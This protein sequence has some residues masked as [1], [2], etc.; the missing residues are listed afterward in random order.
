MAATLDAV[1]EPTTAQPPTGALDPAI[2][3]MKTPKKATPQ[4][5]STTSEEELERK[6]AFKE[7]NTSGDM[8]TEEALKQ[9]GELEQQRLDAF[10]K[11]IPPQP[12]KQNEMSAWGALAIAIGAFASL[13]T[14]QPLTTAM[15]AAASAMTAMQ[16]QNQENFENAFQ[17]WD[18]NVKLSLDMQ[19]LESSAYQDRMREWMSIRGQ[20]IQEERLGV[21]E[22]IAAGNL[23]VK[24]DTLNETH[25]WHQMVNDTKLTALTLKDAT[26]MKELDRGMAEGGPTKALEYASNVMEKRFT[27]T[28]AYK[29]RTLS[30]REKALEVSKQ[31][32]IKS[33]LDD[34]KN[35]DEYKEKVAAGDTTGALQVLAQAAEEADPTLMDRLDKMIVDPSHVSRTADAILNYRM[36][37]K[38]FTGGRGLGNTPFGRAVSDEVSK[39]HEYDETMFA[40]IKKLRSDLATGQ[41]GARLASLT[42]LMGHMKTLEA[43]VKSLPADADYKT[44]NQIYNK[45]AQQY[46]VDLTKYDTAAD[47]VSHEFATVLAGAKGSTALSDREQAAVHFDRDFNKGQ[48]LGNLEIAKELTRSRI[49]A[50]IVR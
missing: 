26:M 24:K 30:L 7:K 1:L 41:T 3:P 6:A 33:A 49:V 8:S 31:F 38:P 48:I 42:M 35:S 19:K 37:G 27:D 18:Q 14:R 9:M 20:G 13:R 23:G 28:K 21:M 22:H 5:T 25:N 50:D 45:F 10:K 17:Q 29:E 4:P 2:E 40:A 15:N 47:A 43:L 46:N 44:I 36:D 32:A 16:Q 34:A 39:H 12:Q 11:T